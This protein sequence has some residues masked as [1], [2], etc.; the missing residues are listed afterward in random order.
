[1]MKK[2]GLISEGLLLP[3]KR[4]LI[5]SKGHFGQNSNPVSII[6]QRRGGGEKR[7]GSRYL[8]MNC[9]LI[10]ME[11]KCCHFWLLL[12]Y[13]I[14]WLFVYFIFGERESNNYVRTCVGRLLLW[15]R[16]TFSWVG[17]GSCRP[18]TIN[19]IPKKLSAFS[20]SLSHSEPT[21]GGSSARGKGNT[22][23]TTGA[24]RKSHNSCAGG[25]NRSAAVSSN[26]MSCYYKLW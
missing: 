14:N 25:V 26:N 21:L 6:E 15:G 9:F 12:I 2:H 3:K 17:L 24:N 5:T 4:I 19:K 7:N 20:L 11:V 23:W 10:F 13:F 22:L 16:V 18:S 1:M 8:A